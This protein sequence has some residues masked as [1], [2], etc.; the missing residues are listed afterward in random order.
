[1]PPTNPTYRSAYAAIPVLHTLPEPLKSEVV[2]AFVLSLRLVWLVA[3]P[4]SVFGILANFFCKEIPLHKH[5][6]EKWG[7]NESVLAEK[8]QEMGR[9]PPPI[10]KPSASLKPV[11]EAAEFGMAC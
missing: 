11:E 3:I 2:H 9:L 4:L 6:D 7:L 10:L 1:M 8:D 5:V